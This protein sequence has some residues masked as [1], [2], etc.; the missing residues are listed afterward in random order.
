M[1]K[2]NLVESHSLLAGSALS[3]GRTAWA[4]AAGAEGDQKK[5]EVLLT[6]RRET[7]TR[8]TGQS[9]AVWGREIRCRDPT[10][11]QCCCVVFPVRSFLSFLG[12]DRGWLP[13]GAPPRHCMH[14]TIRQFQMMPIVTVRLLPSYGIIAEHPSLADGVGSVPVPFLLRS[15]RSVCWEISRTETSVSRYLFYSR[16]SNRSLVSILS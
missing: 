13:I 11:T 15:A 6:G 7:G 8:Q 12:L 5:M 1:L 2:R 4:L 10:I 3:G 9:G 16:F 14:A